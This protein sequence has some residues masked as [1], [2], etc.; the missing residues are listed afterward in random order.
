M[1]YIKQRCPLCEENH[2]SL[3]D[4]HCKKCGSMVCSEHFDINQLLCTKCVRETDEVDGVDAVKE[5][6]EENKLKR[7]MQEELDEKEDTGS[8]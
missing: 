7:L 6:L 4:W 3:A 5:S 8:A 1:R 2:R